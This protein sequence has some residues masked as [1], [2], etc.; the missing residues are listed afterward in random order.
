MRKCRD[1][2]EDIIFV[3]ELNMWL[4]FY[5]GDEGIGTT[6]FFQCAGGPHR[7]IGREQVMN[8]LARVLW[9]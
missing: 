8:D 5:D 1:C 3:P 7:P 6:A 2:G 4:L 9:S